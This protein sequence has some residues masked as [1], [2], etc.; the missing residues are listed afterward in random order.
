MTDKQADVSGSTVTDWY[1]KYESTNYEFDCLMAKLAITVILSD[2][3][4]MVLT[5]G[6]VLL[7][8]GE[9]VRD[10]N[11]FIWQSTTHWILIAVDSVVNMFAINS[12]FEFGDKMFFWC[13]K[14]QHH[15]MTARCQKKMMS[16]TC[17]A[18]EKQVKP[19]ETLKLNAEHPILCQ[20]SQQRPFELQYD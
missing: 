5:I 6:V 20:R 7:L 8:T 18:R 4:S 11:A 12:Q 13:C 1:I 17:E 15:K 19:H 9:F 3:A 10:E 16:H 14:T 2:I